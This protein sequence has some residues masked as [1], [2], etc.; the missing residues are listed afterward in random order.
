M[1]GSLDARKLSSQRIDRK[2]EILTAIQNL[3]WGGTADLRER[4]VRRHSARNLRAAGK[5]H[6]RDTRDCDQA[7]GRGLALRTRTPRQEKLM[8]FRS[9]SQ[10]G[11]SSVLRMRTSVSL[12]NHSFS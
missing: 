10:D 5:L 1:H 11:E 9:R 4:G 6:L 12:G 8:H 7:L 2:S 3:G